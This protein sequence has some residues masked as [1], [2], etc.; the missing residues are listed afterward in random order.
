MKYYTKTVAETFEAVGSSANGLSAVAAKN[1]LRR[2]GLNEVKVAGVPLWKKIIQ[3]FAN[4]MIVMLIVAGCLSLWQRSYVDA[5]IIIVIIMASAIIDWVQQYSTSRILRSLREKEIER[6]DVVRG[7]KAATVPANELVVGDLI[8]LYEGQKVPAD[9]RVV[10]SANLHV[11][12][13]MLTGESMSVRKSSA[14]IKGSKEVYDQLNMLF[15]GSF[16]VSGSGQAVVVATA[17]DTEFGKLAQLAGESSMESPIQQK[18]DALIRWVLIA[19]LILAGVV[20]LLELINGESLINSLQFVLAFA[21]SAVPE[22]LPIAITAVLALGMRR[23][24][25]HKAL[26]RNMRAIENIGL[27]TV[28]ATDKTGTITENKLSVQETWSPRYNSEAFAL[29]ISFTLNVGKKGEVSD[30][31]DQAI[32]NYIRSHQVDNPSHSTKAKLVQTLPFD[33]LLAMSGNVWQFGRKNAVYLKGAPEKLLARCELTAE[34]KAKATEMLSRYASRGYRVIAYAKYDV[35]KSPHNISNVAKSGI[36]FIGLTAVA[37]QLR[38]HIDAAVKT[39]HQAGIKVCMITGDHSETAY[40][41]AQTVCIADDSGQVYDSHKLAKLSPEK[42]AQVVGSTRVYARVTPDTKHAILTE[43]NKHEITA[44]TGDGVNDVPALTQAHVGVAMGSGSAIAK[45]ASDMVL[46]DNNFRS[47][48]V[49]VRE[50]RTI[51]ANIRRM[52]IYL[53]ATNAGEV[54]VTLGALLLGMPLPLLAVQILWINLATDTFL[55]IPLGVEPP[56]G[57]VMRRKPDHPDAPILNKFQAGQMVLSAVVIAAT[58][59]I[60]YVY[61]NNVHDLNYARSAVFLVLIVMQWANALVTRSDE[62]LF[63]IL[64]VRNRAFAFAI[65]GTFV[66]QAIV[67]VVPTF[68]NALH[69]SWLHQDCIFACVLAMVVMVVVIEAYKAIVRHL[70]KGK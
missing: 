6:I 9:A 48:V 28:I 70:T 38:P 46:L 67:L 23:M 55:V 62:S 68:R 24:A 40:N 19:V 45:D 15:S 43:L 18:I 22:S 54:L 7:G 41:I 17:N 8:L 60:T 59:L 29:Q 52:L 27:T 47:I 5:T 1:R 26:V 56:R 36:E 20:F 21:V 32:L 63:K 16:V 42:L 14:A 2:D 3:P 50:G 39:A 33:Y 57:D 34:Q 11:D 66:L 25:A 30:P 4:A 35:A 37:D 69:V 12:E 53:L 49:A 61:F 44:M 13:S 31:L 10:E 51:V 64:K 58:V 65:V